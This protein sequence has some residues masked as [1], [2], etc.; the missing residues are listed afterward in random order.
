M[1]KYTSF[2]IFIMGCSSKTSSTSDTATSIVN[3]DVRFVTIGVFTQDQE[4]YVDTGK[5]L[6]FEVGTPCYSWTRTAQA[7]EDNGSLEAI[8]EVHDHYNSGDNTYYEN[9]SFTWTEYG[10]EHTQETVETV[11]AN[12]EDGVT[13]T[14]TSDQYY[15]DHGG[16]FLKIVSIE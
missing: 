3:E 4:T 6:Y 14:V 7:H 5:T 12:G 8:D 16:L 1:T 13:K 11:C 15:E 9:G 10:P 2:L